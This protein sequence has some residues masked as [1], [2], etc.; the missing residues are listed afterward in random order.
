MKRYINNLIILIGIITLVSCSPDATKKQ[1]YIEGDWLFNPLPEMVGINEVSVIQDERILI[2]STRGL[3]LDNG[4]G[5]WKSFGLENYEVIDVV[6]L[7]SDEYL[8]ATQATS[9]ES[10]DTTLFK[11]TGNQDWVP[12]LQNFG[13]EANTYTWIHDLEKSTDG[14]LFAA[15]T[16][17]V[18]RTTDSGNSWANVYLDW[19][20]L[21]FIFFVRSD[22]KNPDIVWAGGSNAVFEPVLLRSSNNGK[23]WNRLEVIKNVE[24]NILDAIINPKSSREIM[25]S[26]DPIAFIR[27]STN[28]G[29]TWETVQE[30][31]I[32]LSF[33]ESVMN[34]NII[35]ASGINQN[36]TLFFTAS[37]NFGD[38]WQTI[39]FEN[40]PTGIRVNDMISVLQDGKEVLYFGTNKGLYSFTIEN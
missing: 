32:I 28:N 16:S 13:G 20:Y 2:S 36:G 5:N 24:T 26:S 35:Y 37:N 15:G 9:I 4:K 18:I 6:E 14:S 22:K 17:N 11:K 8:A 12:F 7:D 31:N 1:L 30:G 39:V 23:E 40:G 29:E 27:R 34:T 3:Y 25:V 10:G 19:N 33:F 38:T 21:G